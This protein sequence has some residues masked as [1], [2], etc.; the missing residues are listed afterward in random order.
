M[1]LVGRLCLLN[2]IPNA[3]ICVRQYQGATVH[4]EIIF[5]RCHSEHFKNLLDI[6]ATS[7]PWSNYAPN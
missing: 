6:E 7:V 4:S 1:A 2:V 3:V 5:H